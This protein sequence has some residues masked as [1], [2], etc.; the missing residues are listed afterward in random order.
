MEI[1]IEGDDQDNEEPGE[2]VTEFEHKDFEG[3]DFMGA[4]KLHIMEEKPKSI[5]ESMIPLL[6][7]VMRR[8]TMKYVAWMRKSM[9]PVE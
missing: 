7:E 6:R 4:V 3:V 9:C 8:N 2:A 1:S 5:E